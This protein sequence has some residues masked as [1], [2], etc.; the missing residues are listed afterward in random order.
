MKSGM[1]SFFFFLLLF[2]LCLPDLRASLGAAQKAQ[3]NTNTKRKKKKKKSYSSISAILKRETERTDTISGNFSGLLGG[4]AHRK[5][6]RKY[7]S[8][9]CHSTSPSCLFPLTACELGASVHISLHQKDYHKEEFTFCQL[10]HHQ[11]KD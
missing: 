11:A 9:Y 10:K 2:F 3:E 6:I 8:K 1:A 7:L 5:K 4:E